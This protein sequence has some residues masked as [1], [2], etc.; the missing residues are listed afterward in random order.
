MGVRSGVPLSI[1]GANFEG[2]HARIYCM[3]GG[4]YL[5]LIDSAWLVVGLL[6]SYPA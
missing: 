6:N 3:S 2:F 1:R 5:G 4:R